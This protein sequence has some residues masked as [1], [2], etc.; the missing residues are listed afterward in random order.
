MH[1][2]PRY[3]QRRLQLGWRTLRQRIRPVQERAMLHVDSPRPTDGK[4]NIRGWAAGESGIRQIDVC[5][6]DK[7]FVPVQMGLRRQDVAKRHP[8]FP[9]GDKSGY[10]AIVD[11]S[12]LAKGT[13]IVRVDAN[14][15]R[16]RIIGHRMSV[17]VGLGYWQREWSAARLQETLNKME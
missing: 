15:R 10:S 17:P 7:I 14:T 12:G 2:G 13:H 5:I 16:G 9:G 11:V 6:A 4:L 8:E 1:Q 3:W